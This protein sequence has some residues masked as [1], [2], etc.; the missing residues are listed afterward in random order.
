MILNGLRGFVSYVKPSSRQAKLFD[1][2]SIGFFGEYVGFQSSLTHPTRAFS[3]VAVDAFF[4][5]PI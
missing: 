3:Q 5:G 1:A 4:D 2:F